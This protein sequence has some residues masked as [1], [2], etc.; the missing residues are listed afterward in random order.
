MTGPGTGERCVGGVAAP[1]AA[2]RE[3]SHWAGPWLLL[4]LTLPGAA[5][6]SYVALIA[7]APFF[8]ES[9]SPTDR[10]ATSAAFLSGASLWLASALLAAVVFRRV[11]VPVLCGL[12]V[13]CFAALSVPGRRPTA[14]LT[15]AES[16]AWLA[17]WTPP[18]SWVIAVWGATVLLL[19]AFR[20]LR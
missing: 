10:A 7:S 20:R 5:W 14:P 2:R 18:T 1:A 12:A 8:G 4:L 17:A 13:A 9:P 6:S 19:G 3:R 15:A 16:P 11:T